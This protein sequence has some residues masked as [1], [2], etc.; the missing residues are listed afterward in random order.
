MI[1]EYECKGCGATFHTSDPNEKEY[2]D[3][4]CRQGLYHNFDTEPC[5]GLIKR[6]FSFSVRHPMPAHFNKAAGVYVNS[7]RQLKDAFKVQSD[8][9]TERTG[10]EHNLVPIDHEDKKTLGVTSEGLAATYDRR[11]KLGMPI[12]DVVRPENLD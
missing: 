6:V 11:K 12:P 2:M 7:E 3:E 1:Y 8:I 4:A 9:L 10:I 5:N